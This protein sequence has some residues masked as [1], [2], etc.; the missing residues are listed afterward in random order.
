M[1]DERVNI[2]NDLDMHGNEIMNAV[3][4]NLSAAPQ[5][6]GDGLFYFNSTS[7]SIFFWDGTQWRD[8]GLKYEPGDGITINGTTVSV[9]STVAKKTD[10][11]TKI[12]DL[13]DDTETVP[14]DVAETLNG[15]TASITE[16]NYVDGVTSAIQTQIDNKVTKNSDITAGSYG[17]VTVDAKGLVTAGRD[18][19]STDLPDLSASYINTT[20][21]GAANGVAE[22]DS[23][24]KVPPT[25]LPSYVDDVIECL[26]VS[27][28]T[29]FSA[30]WLTDTVGGT[31]LT[32][33]KGKIYVVTSS[34]T[35]ANK[36]YRWSGTQYVELIP[37]LNLASETGSGIIEIATQAETN[38]GTDDTRAVTPK[39]LAGYTNGMA[40]KITATNP[41]LTPV[42]GICSWVITNTL[43]TKNVAIQMIEVSS[44]NDVIP[45]KNCTASTITL[46]INSAATIAAGTYEV[47]IVG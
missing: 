46:R 39:K 35:Y 37:T 41:A 25:Q 15:L 34:G 42:S 45:A 47:T 22:L 4:Q 13:T 31:A 44:G 30:G 3:A 5:N 20:N 19:A 8:T 14:V 43:G 33:E 1:S 36:Q 10:L 38:T 7:K 26:I 32:P 24:G 28:S 17:I 9:D 29:E 40:K 16:L 12:S 11:P 18:I 2:L 23:T 27:G 6:P 21:K